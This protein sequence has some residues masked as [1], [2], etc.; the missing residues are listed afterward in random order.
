[1]QG[2]PFK[3]RPRRMLV[4]LDDGGI[5]LKPLEIRVFRQGQEDPLDNAVLNPAVIAPLDGLIIPDCA[6]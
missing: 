5:D 4:S 3:R 6:A 2:P 1:M